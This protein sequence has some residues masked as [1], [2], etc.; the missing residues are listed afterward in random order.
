M[1]KLSIIVPTLNEAAG[2]QAQLT[3]LQALREAG[4]ELI[5]VDGGSADETT[6]VA[7]PLA[8]RL[9]SAPRGRGRQM[10]AG[11]AQAA[12]D[13]LLFLHGDTSLPE[14]A[15]DLILQGLAASGRTWGRFDVA[16][17]GRHFLLPVIAWFMNHRSRLTGI[18][19]GDQGMFVRRAAFAALGGFPE[20]PLM[21][22]IVLSRRL[23]A[24]GPP[25]CIHRRAVT[26]GRRWDKH[27]VLGTVLLM[28]CLRLAFFL[29][30]DTRWLAKCYGYHPEHD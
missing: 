28:W 25:L 1:A 30:A 10:N 18:A 12:G 19:T 8:D 21:E 7:R 20:I 24:F 11:A 13:V 26:S 4:S 23:H 14:Q 16:I 27:G 22:D 17:D 3:A 15:D 2:I 9:L 6:H 5:V 29:G